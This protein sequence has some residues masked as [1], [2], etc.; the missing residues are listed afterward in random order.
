[1]LFNLIANAIKFKGDEL[2]VIEILCREV[3][4]VTTLNIS[5]NGK[6]MSEKDM[7]KIFQIY[8]RLH[9]DIEG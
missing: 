6:G 1:M 7:G 3:E 8:G 9:Q 5:D 4:G 2:P